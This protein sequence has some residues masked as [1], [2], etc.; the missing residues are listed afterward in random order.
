MVADMKLA[1]TNVPF[2]HNSACIWLTSGQD[3]KGSSQ[4][5]QLISHKYLLMDLKKSNYCF[6]SCILVN[7][8]KQRFYI[9]IERRLFLNDVFLF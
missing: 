1:F 8:L 6:T 4:S 7:W 2:R 9:A 5:D 3:L